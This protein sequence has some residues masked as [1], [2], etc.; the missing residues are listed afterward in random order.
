VRVQS[1]PRRGTRVDVALPPTSD[2]PP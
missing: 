1:A 2:G